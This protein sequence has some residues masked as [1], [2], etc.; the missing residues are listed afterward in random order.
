M[1]TWMKYV[2]SLALTLYCLGTIQ[3]SSWESCSL[4]QAIERQR[5]DQVITDE[6]GVFLLIDGC[7]L[8]SQG[9]QATSEGIL[10]LENGE[11]IPLQEAV[12][13]DNY[14][15]WQCRNCK[16]WNSESTSRCYYCKKSR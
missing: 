10:I 14:Y 1:R 2:F 15:V 12:K 6:Q 16:K 11:W 9:M 3:A 13:C 5:I 7:W 4:N 8:G